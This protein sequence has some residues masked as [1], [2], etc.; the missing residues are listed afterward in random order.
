MSEDNHE[1]HDGD[2]G[3]LNLNPFKDMLD[4]VANSIILPFQQVV[5]KV[6]EAV[7]GGALEQFQKTIQAF[8][9]ALQALVDPDISDEEIQRRISSYQAWG[10]YGWVVPPEAPFDLFN[11]APSDLKTAN[12]IAMQ[13]C[14][15]QDIESIF[16]E[17]EQQK[18]VRKTDLQEAKF[19]FDNKKY[20]SCV[21]IL[22]SM[23]DARLIR[24]S[25]K[26]GKEKQRPSG[27][28]AANRLIDH[29][30]Q[31]YDKANYLFIVLRLAGLQ[32][33]YDCIFARGNDFKMQ[34]PTI[35]RNFIDHGMRWKRVTKTECIQVLLLYHETITI[36]DF[37]NVK[38]MT[39]TF[40][41]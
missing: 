6:R 31:K 30:K 26:K 18:H 12:R 21:M 39:V 32:A 15:P 41:H 35:N 1:N 17:L 7:I 22:F 37:L 23:I 11:T 14:K 33:C 34:V 24:L 38:K 28:E 40:K 29:I 19:C 27:S 4:T 8:G 36:L 3:N 25:A 2:L 5:T 16:S 13:Y 10:N 9:K 20:K